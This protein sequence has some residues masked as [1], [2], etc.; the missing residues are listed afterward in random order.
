[1]SPSLIQNSKARYVIDMVEDL[2]GRGSAYSGDPFKCIVFSQF[3]NVLNVL[4]SQLILRFGQSAVAEFWGKYR[5]LELEKFT[6]GLQRTWKCTTCG[7]V[8]EPL[9]KRCKRQRLKVVIRNNH[10]Q[11]QEALWTGNVWADEIQGYFRGFSFQRL[12]V[13]SIRN[14]GTP[15]LQGREDYVTATVV[16]ANRCNEKRRKGVWQREN[17]DCFLLLLSRDGSTGLDLSMVTHVILLDKIWDNAIEDQVISRAWR[18]GT[19]A[20]EINA[21]QLYMKG[22]VEQIMFDAEEQNSER[23]RKKNDETNNGK[24]MAIMRYLF[25]N[26]KIL[27]SDRNVENRKKRRRVMFDVQTL[28]TK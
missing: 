18:L 13:V 4:G 6:D 8:N 5:K 23:N 22:T 20:A 12:Q 24:E 15:G 10:G 11:L 1:M 17:V 21:I 9:E 28:I 14:P 3:R 7:Y 19:R 16:D 25:S 2:H 26:L 27:K